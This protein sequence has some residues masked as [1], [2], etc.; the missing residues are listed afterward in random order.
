MRENWW[1]YALAFALGATA[2]VIVCKNSK[3]IRTVCTKAIGGA[4]DVKDMV[5]EKAEII[6]ESAED[7]IAEADAQRKKDAP[8][9]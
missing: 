6:K 5:M 1:K 2:G 7:L 4:L 9:V 8:E 3:Q